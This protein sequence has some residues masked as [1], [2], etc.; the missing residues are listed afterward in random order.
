MSI[1]VNQAVAG[2]V[3]D[4]FFEVDVETS[5]GDPVPG[6]TCTISVPGGG[7]IVS[8]ITNSN[9]VFSGQIM[10]VITGD[11]FDVM[12]TLGSLGASQTLTIG[13]G[14]TEIVSLIFAPLVVGGEVISIEATS[15]I[16][17]AAQSFSWMIPVVLSGIGIGLFVFRRSENS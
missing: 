3:F 6:A 17:T 10:D 5:L 1:N 2:A 8:G 15:L 13:T 16:L 14:Q 12:C 9:G 4:V 11:M 7:I